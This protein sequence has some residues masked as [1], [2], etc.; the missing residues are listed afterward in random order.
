MKPVGEFKY[1]AYLK[2]EPSWQLRFFYIILMII[3]SFCPQILT[4]VMCLYVFNLGFFIS[5]FN[6]CNTVFL[7]QK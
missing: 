1:K 6:C 7:L 2:I 5:Y 4:A 3:K